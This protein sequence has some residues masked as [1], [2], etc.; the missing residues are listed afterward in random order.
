MYTAVIVYMLSTR[1]GK[2]ARTHLIYFVPETGEV[3]PVDTN[4]AEK[5]LQVCR[6]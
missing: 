5:L 3:Q 2:R 6:S 1:A 4:V